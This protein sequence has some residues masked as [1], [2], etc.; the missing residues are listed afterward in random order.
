M[1]YL[2]VTLQCCTC[3]DGDAIDT[4]E[5]CVVIQ[6]NYCFTPLGP[7]HSGMKEITFRIA[8]GPINAH[9]FLYDI[10]KGKTTLSSKDRLV[11]LGVR[12]CP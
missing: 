10:S 7:D 12:F 3:V 5:V 1:C 9:Y 8:S 2:Y 6:V 4:I 11:T